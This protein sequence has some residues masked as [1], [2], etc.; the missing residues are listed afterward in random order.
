MMIIAAI[1]I[2]ALMKR[3]EMNLIK[4]FGNL[5]RLRIIRTI[6]RNLIAIL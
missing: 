3:K 6:F 1:F 5:I 2:R 4:L